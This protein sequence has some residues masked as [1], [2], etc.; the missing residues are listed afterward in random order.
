MWNRSEVLR[1]TA[2]SIPPLV[3]LGLVRFLVFDYHPPESLLHT[4]D[5][6]FFIDAGIRR[7][8][9]AVYGAVA[10]IMMAIFLKAVEAR[11]QGRANLKGLAFGTA[12]GVVWSFGFLTGWLFLGTTLAAELLNS[13]VDALALAIA[14]SLMGWAVGRD[15][16]TI[17]H[18]PRRAWSAVLLIAIGFVAIHSLGTSLIAPL[19]PSTASLLLVPKTL[20]QVT[21]LLGLGVWVGLMYAVLRAALPF[22]RPLARAAFFAFGVFGHCW[23]W[24]HVFFVIEFAGVL[25]ATLLVGVIGATGTF[26]GALA[27]ERLAGK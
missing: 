5:R 24:F 18:G 15:I 21:L 19:L 14:G 16:P 1:V 23:T 2:V 22:E 10:F 11:W 7:P 6:S 12:L 8:A 20:P 3:G 25:P 27:Y 4:L 26:V 9:M 13:M 17:S